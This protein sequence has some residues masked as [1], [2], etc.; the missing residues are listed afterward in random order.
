MDPL[1]VFRIDELCQVIACVILAT[2]LLA[3]GFQI[4]HRRDFRRYGRAIAYIIIGVLAAGIA[5]AT[6]YLVGFGFA[7]FLVK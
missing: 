6:I 4:V 5:L 3:R 2:L 1:A 7:R